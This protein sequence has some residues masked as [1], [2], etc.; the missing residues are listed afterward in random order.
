MKKRGRQCTP[1]CMSCVVIVLCDNVSVSWEVTV[2]MK[3]EKGER[4]ELS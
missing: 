3:E 1:L 2:N 4:N